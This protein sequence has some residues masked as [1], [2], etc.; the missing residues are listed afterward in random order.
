MGITAFPRPRRAVFDTFPG[1]TYTGWYS[2][3]P[4]AMETVVLSLPAT[5][6]T[7]IVP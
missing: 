1:E 5:T 4:D 7:S 6:G 3:C 2:C